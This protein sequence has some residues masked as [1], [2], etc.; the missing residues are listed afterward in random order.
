MKKMVIFRY[1]R[2][3]NNHSEIWGKETLRVITPTADFE[4]YGKNGAINKAEFEKFSKDLEPSSDGYD[5]C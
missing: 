3:P 1:K 2:N 4:G 5:L